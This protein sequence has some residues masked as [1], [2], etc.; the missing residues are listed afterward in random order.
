[1]SDSVI[2]VSCHFELFIVPQILTIN[3]IN[4]GTFSLVQA[5][6]S[7]AGPGNK[8]NNYGRCKFG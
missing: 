5:T 4:R 7:W 3:T 6:P 1:M 8:A 2:G